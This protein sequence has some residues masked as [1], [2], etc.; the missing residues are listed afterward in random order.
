MRSLLKKEG[1]SSRRNRATREQGHCSQWNRK[2]R[3][4]WAGRE[5]ADH[6][7][8]VGS[9]TLVSLETMNFVQHQWGWLWGLPSGVLSS[10][11]VMEEKAYRWGLHQEGVTERHLGRRIENTG[12][13][14]V[15]VVFHDSRLIRRAMNPLL[16]SPLQPTTHPPTPL[17]QHS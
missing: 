1:M 6:R 10:P 4:K 13:K 3:E 14:I 17:P 2:E 12:A 11:G 8:R 15:G 7:N 16:P 5:N 9:P